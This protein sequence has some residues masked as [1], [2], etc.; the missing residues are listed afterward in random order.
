MARSNRTADRMQGY[1][2]PRT[3]Q[4]GTLLTSYKT[5][6]TLE[7]FMFIS[8]PLLLSLFSL[9]TVQ[10]CRPTS[11]WSA[12]RFTLSI[13]CLESSQ[14]HQS[15]CRIH[16]PSFNSLTISQSAQW[17]TD[18]RWGPYRGFDS[19]STLIRRE[20]HSPLFITRNQ[21]AS[22]ASRAFCQHRRRLHRGFHRGGVA[23]SQRLIAH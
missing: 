21:R 9:S 16:P 13:S 23:R 3:G 10:S 15:L 11:A 17:T 5:N 19:E 20:S 18:C 4:P 1:L 2:C 12:Q 7:L 6:S 22:R 14:L 8:S